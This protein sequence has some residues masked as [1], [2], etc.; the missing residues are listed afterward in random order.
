MPARITSMTTVTAMAVA[1]AC[2]LAPAATAGRPSGH[3]AAALAPPVIHEPFTS[4]PCTGTPRNR[5]TV[6]MVECA[7]QAILAGDR[8]IDTLNAQIFAKLGTA[9]A[10]RDFIAGHDAWLAY[11]RAYCI[12]IS[13]VFQGGTEASVLDGQCQAGLN[14]EHV[15]DLQRFL[16]DLTRG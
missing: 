15:E 14:A 9:S 5:S 13:D 8:N 11:R 7:E 3:R 4:A 16:R 1:A 6:Q 2:A 10:R 12:S